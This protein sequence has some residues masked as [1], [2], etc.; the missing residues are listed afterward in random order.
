VTFCQEWT[1]VKHS[2]E[3][4]TATPLYCRSWKCET[5]GPKR[6]SQLIAEAFRGKPTSFLTLTCRTTAFEKPENGA[7][8]LAATWRLIVKR[9]KREATRDPARTPQPSPAGYDWSA[10][11]DAKGRVPPQV[12]LENGKLPFLAVFE[13]TA[14]GW[15]HLHIIMRVPWMDQRWVSAQMDDLMRSPICWIERIADDGRIVHYISK[16][17][18]KNSQR[19]GKCKRYWS[20]QNWKKP[21]EDKDDDDP[22]PYEHYKVVEHNIETYIAEKEADG[23]KPERSRNGVFFRFDLSRGQGPPLID[24]SAAL[25]SA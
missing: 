6:K 1:L 15:P 13:A 12:R 4:L 5:C 11:A 14:K 3:G 17:V 2:E 25:R 9:A 10:K 8:A 23:W 22:D 21:D 20:T 18:G 7:Q 19:F 24:T 16:Y